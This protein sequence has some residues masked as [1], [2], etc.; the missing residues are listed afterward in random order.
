MKAAIVALISIIALMTS[1]LAQPSSRKVLVLQ[2]DGDA[3][4]EQRAKL[5]ESVVKMAK[6]K[7]GADVTMGEVTFSEAASAAGCDP[8]LASCAESVRTTLAVDELVY[9]T[10]NTTDGTTTITLT[11]VTAGSQPMSQTSAISAT[12]PPETAESGLAPVFNT[13]P[14][15]GSADGSGA[16][17]GS[18]DRGRPGTSFFD[19]TER[20]L[21]VG[22]L[23]G[24][25]IALV[26]GFSLWSGASGLQQDIDDHPK[27]T[28]T[29]IN[30]LKELEDEAASKALWGNIFV[31]IG[32]AAAGTGGYFLWKD[33]KN[34][35]HATVTPA[36]SPD[37]TGMSFVLRGRW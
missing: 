27:M 3:P 13:T 12:D 2:L 17:S 36:P 22:F 18:A 11:R 25:V 7:L 19:T 31:V 20:K 34:R 21:G 10:A 29:Q 23:A 9:G 24:G 28:L 15:V 16:G 26:I 6:D 8:I 33:R 32:L 5:N 14:E 30:D 1:V 4:A 35:A 37:G